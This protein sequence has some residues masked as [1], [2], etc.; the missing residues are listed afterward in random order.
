[1]RKSII[2]KDILLSLQNG[3][4]DEAVKKFITCEEADNCENIKNC[5]DRCFIPKLRYMAL[6]LR[7][8]EF[9]NF[10]EYL[11]KKYK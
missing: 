4:L 10:A 6:S 1:M 7:N 9:D 3:H 8:P 5:V 11:E 2:S